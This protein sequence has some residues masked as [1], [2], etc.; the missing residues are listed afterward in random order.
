MLPKAVKVPDDVRES[1]CKTFTVD[2]IQLQLD[3]KA[4][5]VKKARAVKGKTIDKKGG[6]RFQWG[7]DI[8]KAWKDAVAAAK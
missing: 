2:G 6:A 4:L 7:D 1:M 3:K 8:Q 5:Y